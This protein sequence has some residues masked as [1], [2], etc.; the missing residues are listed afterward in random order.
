MAFFLLAETDPRLVAILKV[1]LVARIPFT[2]LF[3]ATFQLVYSRG[4]DFLGV[5]GV[6]FVVFANR[7]GLNLAPS[8]TK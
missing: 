2:W 6:L 7:L 8:P 3:F 4:G 1:A 5:A